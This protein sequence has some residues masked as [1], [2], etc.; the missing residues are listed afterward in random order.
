ML[1][2]LSAAPSGGTLATV[3]TLFEN[4]SI[5]E[6]KASHVPFALS[7]LPHPQ[8]TSTK[9]SFLR[10]LTGLA[11]V[12][13]LGLLTTSLAGMTDAAIVER[14]WGLLSV[15]PS[16]KEQFYG[17]NFTFK[18]Y[19]RTPNWFRGMIQH[20]AMTLFGFVLIT[21][22]LRKFIWSFVHQPGQGPDR[23]GARKDRIE[24]RGV[25]NPDLEGKGKQAFSR[26]YF[27]GSMYYRK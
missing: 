19:M 23:E 14:T 2:L 27:N 6:V 4:F 24:Y 5:R 21:P 26:A 17:P 7:P 16:R 20:Y 13:N 18:E 12:P 22:P 1:T 3:F 25:G 15:N 9:R 10:S 11:K 8:P